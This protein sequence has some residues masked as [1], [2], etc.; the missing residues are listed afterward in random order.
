MTPAQESEVTP[1]PESRPDKQVEAPELT[2]VRETYPDDNQVNKINLLQTATPE[3]NNNVES[4]Q[5]SHQKE[6]DQDDVERIQDRKKI[7]K[8]LGFWAI[9]LPKTR[10]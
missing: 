2:Y 8:E 4:S 6:L 1:E 10:R 7:K 9:P 5:E 3:K